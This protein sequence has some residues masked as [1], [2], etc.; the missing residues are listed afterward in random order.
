MQVTRRSDRASH[1]ASADPPATTPRHD[2]LAWGRYLAMT[3]CTECHGLDLRGF[4]GDD[5]PGLRVVAGYPD[6]AFEALLRTGRG[7]GD[8]ELGLMGEVALSRFQHFT[9]EEIGALRAWL[10]HAIERGEI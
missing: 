8:R 10:R 1:A 3:A 5:A 7:L 2:P 6:E 9:D 4:P